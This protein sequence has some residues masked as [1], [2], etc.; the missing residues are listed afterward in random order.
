MVGLVLDQPVKPLTDRMAEM[1]LIAIPTNETI[2]R[3]LPPLNVKESE[4]EEAMEIVEDALAES[5]GQAPA[6]DRE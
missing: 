1:G 6:A 4:L 2:V 3:F 5:H